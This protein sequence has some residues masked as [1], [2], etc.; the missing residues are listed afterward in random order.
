M[1]TEIEETSGS[2][3][4]LSTEEKPAET[5]SSE[6]AEKAQSGPSTAADKLDPTGK[7]TGWDFSVPTEDT[8][9]HCLCVLLA[10][11]PTTTI[12]AYFV[13]F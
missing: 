3:E 2:G 1:V 12:L 7:L 11:L 6:S 9:G 13:R 10:K 5:E 4:G 8:G